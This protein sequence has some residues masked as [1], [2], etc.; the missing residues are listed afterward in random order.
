MTDTGSTPGDNTYATFVGSRLQYPGQNPI[1]YD[2]STPA[3]IFGASWTYQLPFGKG[4]TF[5]NKINTPT[6]LFIG[7]WTFSGNLRYTDGTALQIDALSPFV[8]DFGYQNAYG[9]PEAFANYVGGNPHGHWSGKY[10]PYTDSCPGVLNGTNSATG[11]YFNPAAF[12]SPGFFA[13]GN[14]AS[15]LPWL[16]GFTQGSESLELGKT[17]PIHERLNFDLSGDF[18]NPFNIVRW[19]NPGTFAVGIPGFGQVTNTQ[20]S[21]RQI[22]INMKVRF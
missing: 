22:Q 8:E 10:N 15:A 21:P 12:T 3:A 9:P 1:T 5:A 7:G 18:V 16:R 19:A 13:F 4:R 17:L 11:C 20:G 14:T 2:P 6:D